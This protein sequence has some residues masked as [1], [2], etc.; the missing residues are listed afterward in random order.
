MQFF[1]IAE[2]DGLLTDANRAGLQKRA[3]PPALAWDVEGNV[4]AKIAGLG[5]TAMPVV[6]LLPLGAANA[7]QR[8]KR[9]GL[10]T[11][12]IARFA[13]KHLTHSILTSAFALQRAVML[14]VGVVS[15]LYANIAGRSSS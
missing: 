12:M 15:S 6:V 8:Q 3:V 13:G 7:K 4:Y 10:F 2:P 5:L 11:S 9:T 14:V 1:R